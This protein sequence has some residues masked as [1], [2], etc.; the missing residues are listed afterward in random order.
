MNAPAGSIVDHKYGDG[1]DNRKINL[2]IATEA[3]NRYNRRKTSKR[4][5][6]KYKGVY[7]KK[8]CSKYC[9]V[10]GCNGKKTFLGHFDNEIDAAKA[11]DEAAK[12]LFGEFARLNFTTK[13]AEDSKVL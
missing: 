8:Q 6:S 4:T 5:S 12:K 13:A 10:I 9:A 1:L 11:Y 2:R 7:Y 3:Q